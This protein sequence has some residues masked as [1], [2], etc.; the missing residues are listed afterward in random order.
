MVYLFG[1]QVMD[2]LELS[3]YRRVRYV[4]EKEIL[5][6]KRG[7][8]LDA[9]GDLLVST[10]SF[11]QVDLDRGQ[12]DKWA[13]KNGVHLDEAFSRVADIFETNT[14]LQRD[15][16]LRRLNMGNKISS[17][18]ISNRIKESELD[19]LIKEF[20]DQKMSGLLHNFSYMRRIYSKERLAARILGSVKEISDDNLSG[21]TTRSIYKLSGICGI[22]ASADRPLSGEY[23][24]REIV[25]DANNERVPYPNLREKKPSNGHNVWLTIDSRV[26]EIVEEA[27]NTGLDAYSAKNAAAVVMQPSTGKIIAMAGIS[28]TDR[29]EDPSIVRTKPNIPVSFMFEPGSTMK[30]LTLLPALENKLIS[31]TE[32]IPS[33]AMQVGR[34][35]ITDTHHYGPLNAR[36]I[37][38]KSSNVGI[39]KIADRIGS[40]KMY[41]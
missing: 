9:N 28:H 41:E 40:P 10:I 22:E 37:I 24:W 20:R 19:G 29:F 16:V 25:R 36:D 39:A 2:P 34:R 12:I 17:I 11:Y 13:T 4:P 35:R 15:F 5:I 3:G 32:K 7:A 18:Q 30:P 27:L 38:A 33:G 8:V 23:G 26:Q 14:S 1:I 31:P 6:P 21:G